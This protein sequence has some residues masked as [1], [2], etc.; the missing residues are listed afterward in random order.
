MED[1][2]RRGRDIPLAFFYLLDIIFETIEPSPK[3]VIFQVELCG[4]GYQRQTFGQMQ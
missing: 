3:S 2:I 1:E 4:I